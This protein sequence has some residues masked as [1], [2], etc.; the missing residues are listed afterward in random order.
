[1]MNSPKDHIFTLETED[2]ETWAPEIIILSSVKK[3]NFHIQKILKCEQD[4]TNFKRPKRQQMF[5]Q[6]NFYKRHYNVSSWITSFQLF[7]EK[8]STII[9]CQIKKQDSYTTVRLTKN[10]N[11]FVLKR[12]ENSIMSTRKGSPTENN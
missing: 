9:F 7:Y 3:L 11:V 1:M 10:N 4:I 5:L 2:R 8:P 12:K 6:R